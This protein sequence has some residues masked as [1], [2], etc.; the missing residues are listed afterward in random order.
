MRLGGASQ[1][2]SAAASLMHWPAVIVAELSTRGKSAA[3]SIESVAFSFVRRGHPV[4]QR[5]QH[6]HYLLGQGTF[7]LRAQAD[8]MSATRQLTHTPT[9]YPFCTVRLGWYTPNPLFANL[10]TI[11]ASGFKKKCLHQVLKRL[12]R[13]PN[14]AA[15]SIRLRKFT[16]VSAAP[17]IT[18]HW[19]SNSPTT[20]ARHG[21]AG[22][23]TNAT[24]SKDSTLR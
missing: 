23:F 4:R 15:L 3:D 12:S 18:A 5:A 19:A 6:A 20:C 14:G 10:N 17:G 13:S 21:G 24:I 9:S 16:V 22:W 11:S 7:A 8:R 2:L 1:D